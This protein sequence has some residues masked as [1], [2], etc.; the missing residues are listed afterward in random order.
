MSNV[1]QMSLKRPWNGSRCFMFCVFFLFISF[2]QL[3]TV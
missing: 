3:R 2:S 1:T